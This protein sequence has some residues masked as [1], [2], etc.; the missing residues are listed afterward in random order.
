ML[1]GKIYFTEENAGPKIQTEKLTAC[2]WTV[3]LGTR[4]ENQKNAAGIF[5]L[6]LGTKNLDTS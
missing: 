1:E 4:F 6:Q 5:E 2:W 3:S